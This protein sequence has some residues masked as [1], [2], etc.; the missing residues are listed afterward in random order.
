MQ[1]G[2]HTVYGEERAHMSWVNKM[3][4]KP[5]NPHRLA[6][7][8]ESAN[9]TSDS[10]DLMARKLE[11]EDAGRTA[12]LAKGPLCQVCNAHG[13]KRSAEDSKPAHGQGSVEGPWCKVVQGSLFVE[14][15]QRSRVTA[16]RA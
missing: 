9:G 16:C 13:C 4:A 15:N 6:G 8:E 14:D 2:F 10:V 7:T 3:T 1:L 5:E 12:E 11:G